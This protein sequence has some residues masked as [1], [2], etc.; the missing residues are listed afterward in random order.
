MVELPLVVQLIFPLVTL[1]ASIIIISNKVNDF[2]NRLRVA[3][4]FTYRESVFAKFGRQ[5]WLDFQVS[6]IGRRPIQSLQ[7]RLYCPK[8]LGAHG[9]AGNIG[10]EYDPY[11]G[12]NKPFFLIPQMNLHEHQTASF[13]IAFPPREGGEYLV[14]LHLMFDGQNKSWKHRI[15]FP[16][17]IRTQT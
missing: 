10:R 14:E 11:W 13:G 5:I 2:L 12:G 4:Q 6:N 17:K 15:A 7:G 8:D 1:V 16:I 9:T 3:V